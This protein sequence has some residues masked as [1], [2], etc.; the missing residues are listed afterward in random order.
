[1]TKSEIAEVVVKA[2]MGLGI[3][4]LYGYC[5]INQIPIPESLPHFV[6]IA[7][8]G[9]FLVTAIT[10]ATHYNNLHKQGSKK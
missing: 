4:G 3:L 8:G 2:I 5:I 1:M 7:L 6:E 9:Y 10:R